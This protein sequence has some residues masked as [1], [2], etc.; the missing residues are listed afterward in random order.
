MMWIET[1]N[2]DSGSLY[3]GS[4]KPCEG[5]MIQIAGELAP[6]RITYVMGSARKGWRVCTKGYGA[7]PYGQVRWLLLNSSAVLQPENTD[8]SS[9]SISDE[10]IEANTVAL[11]PAQVSTPP[12]VPVP[13][14]PH[15]ELE[16]LGFLTTMAKHVDAIIEESCLTPAQVNAALLMLE[17]KGFAQRLPGNVYIRLK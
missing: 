1:S 5:D 9:M 2:D 17:L 14:L 12:S 4:T 15:E 11:S 13:P 6:R 8:L 7:F 16:L 10:T 3:V